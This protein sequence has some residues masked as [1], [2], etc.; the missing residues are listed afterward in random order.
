MPSRIK[1][2]EAHQRETLVNIREA[3]HREMPKFV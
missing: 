3:T 1:L 2:D